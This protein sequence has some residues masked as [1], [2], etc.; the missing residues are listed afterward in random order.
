VREGAVKRTF[1]PDPE[2]QGRRSGG[3]ETAGNQEAN[4]GGERIGGSPGTAPHFSKEEVPMRPPS[5]SAY[6]LTDYPPYDA[7]KRDGDTIL[8]YG[9]TPLWSGDGPPP[10]L[11]TRILVKMNGL[12]YGTVRGYFIESGWLGVH[13]ELENPPDWWKKQ[14]A[15]ITG[16]RLWSTV[17]GMEV[18]ASTP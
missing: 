8:N 14:T 2:P 5:T 13:V 17:F 18:A 15:G 7:P 4:R 10:R 12:G 1:P 9:D 11:G 16:K 6:Y 3:I